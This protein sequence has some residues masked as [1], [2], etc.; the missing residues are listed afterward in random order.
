[1]DIVTRLEYRTRNGKFVPLATSRNPRLA[2]LVANHI[3]EE[4]D[5]LTETDFG[6]ELLNT[7]AGQE[8]NHIEKI[9]AAMGLGEGHNGH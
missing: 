8:R 6:D 4:L 5:E 3:L 7:L 2:L 1:M 9:F